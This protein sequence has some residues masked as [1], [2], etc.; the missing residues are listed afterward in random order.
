LLTVQDLRQRARLIV[1]ATGRHIMPPWL[2]ESNYG[3]FAGERRLRSEEVELIARWLKDG[4]PEG[5]P[6]DRRAPPA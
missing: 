4:M 6:P 3:A 2:P 5:D 1:D